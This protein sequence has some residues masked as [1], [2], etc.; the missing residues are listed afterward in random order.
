MYEIL[1]TLPHSIIQ[2][3]AGMNEA[4]NWLRIF[5]FTAYSLMFGS[6]FGSILNRRTNQLSQA[7]DEREYILQNYGTDIAPE[8]A[9]DP[10]RGETT[11]VCP[12]CH[13]KLKF[14]HNIPIISYLLLMGK[15]GFCDQKISKSYPLIEISVMS[16]MVMFGYITNYQF[17]IQCVW[18]LVLSISAV[19]ICFTDLKSMHIYDCDSIAFSISLISILNKTHDIQVS[20]ILSVI[21]I[22]V[23]IGLVSKCI[24]F[25]LKRKGGVIG[26]GDFPLMA[27][28]A[29]TVITLA[30]IESPLSGLMLTSI[31]LTVNPLIVAVY[32]LVKKKTISKEI[33]FAPIIVTGIMMMIIS[34]GYI[35]AIC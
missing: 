32:S 34:N 26:G 8:L 35:L 30:P 5:A 1:T 21:Y 20:T 2:I 25:A 4:P 6:L 29:L 9:K 23:G 17:S 18:F 12:N 13:N 3:V 7:Q 22:V 27:S 16:L 24:G 10:Y 15:C 19:S 28:Y 11:S 31:L 14:Y 33:P